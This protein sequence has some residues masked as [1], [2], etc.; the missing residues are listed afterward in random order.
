M[1]DQTTYDPLVALREYRHLAP[2]NLSGLTS[3]VSALLG[4]SRVRPINAAAAT[5]PN[6]RTVR[7]YVNRGLVAPPE[8]RGTSAIYHYRHLLQLLF[9]KLRQM[10]GATLT[11][12]EEELK[13]L[14]GDVIERRVAST[15]GDE[16]PSPIDLPLISSQSNQ[17]GRSGRVFGTRINPSDENQNASEKKDS[18]WVR[19]SIAEGIELHVAQD[20]PVLK[21]VGDTTEISRAV[22]MTLDR[23]IGNAS[24]GT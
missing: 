18:A 9:I 8:G 17:S 10:E 3:L 11:V 15:L 6:Q 19:V 12:I 21:E 22:G 4:V 16:L 5:V 24:S 13:R 2:W 23:L 7:F 1:S 20:H 14:T